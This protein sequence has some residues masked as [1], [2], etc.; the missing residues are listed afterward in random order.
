MALRLQLARE[1]DLSKIH[2]MQQEAFK[3]FTQKYQS[4][5]ANLEKEDLAESIKRFH[6]TGNSYYFIM[7]NKKPVGVI[8]VVAS[9]RAVM[10]HLSLLWIMPKFQRKGFGHKA[11]EIVENMYGKKNWNLNVIEQ[12]S[13]VIRFYEDVGYRKTNDVK[14]INDRLSIMVMD[15]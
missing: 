5:V 1:E 15:K 8:C 6:R 11:V 7:D 3:G 12:E 4:D 9:L 2:K 13:D 10:K 14:K